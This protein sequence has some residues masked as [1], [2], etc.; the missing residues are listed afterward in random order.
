[1]KAVIFDFD[2]T[3][4]E[5]RGNLWKKIW[6]TLGYEIGEGSYYM[7]LLNSFL[8]NKLTHKRWCELTCEAYQDKSFN[9]ELL[10]D[11]VSSIKLMPGLEDL[12]KYLNEKDIQIHIVSGN[13]MS[14]INKVLGDNR[15]YVTNITANEF[16]FDNNGFLKEI[17][18]TKYDCEGKA[19]YI[20]ELCEKE[21]FNKTDVL[22]V[23]NSLN[24]EWVHLSK[25]K[26]ICINPDNTKSE[27]K[28][29]W[30]KVIYTDNL[31]DLVKEI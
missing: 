3:L 21:N 29:I 22:F 20:E 2:G 13:I 17:V 14:V 24:D 12:F 28:T 5:K 1:M 26:T 30:N 10:E 27:D 9:K 15:K 11:L 8:D 16:I 19:K 31:M 25:V 4:T 7:S 18:G 23:G 6:S